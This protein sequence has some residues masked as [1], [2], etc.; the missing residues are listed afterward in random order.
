MNLINRFINVLFDLVRVDDI[1]ED[2]TLGVK[3]DGVNREAHFSS[4][5]LV[6]LKQ[7]FDLDSDDYDSRK[8][9]INSSSNLMSN[10]DPAANVG[11]HRYYPASMEGLRKQLLDVQNHNHLLEEEIARLKNELAEVRER[12]RKL[13][14][15]VIDSAISG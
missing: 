5:I 4:S 7:I 15:A 2:S 1:E 9:Y 8:Q 3:R 12:A 14:V 13:F 6:D 10:K 11:C